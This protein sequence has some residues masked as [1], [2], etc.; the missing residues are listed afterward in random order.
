[1]TFGERT[2]VFFGGLISGWCVCSVHSLASWIRRSPQPVSKD[3]ANIANC[4]RSVVT[5]TASNNALLAIGIIAFTSSTHT[6]DSVTLRRLAIHPSQALGIARKTSLTRLLVKSS[7]A[8]AS[9][10][11]ARVQRRKAGGK[12]TVYDRRVLVTNRILLDFALREARY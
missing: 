3:H 4:E 7:K 1:M 2:R 11:P 10:A 8:A 5:Y 12:S 9:V 6:P